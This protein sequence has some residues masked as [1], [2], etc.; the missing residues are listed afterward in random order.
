MYQLLKGKKI[1]FS[2]KLLNHNHFYTGIQ[3]P[4]GNYPCLTVWNFF[5]LICKF[6]PWICLLIKSLV[7]LNFL[8]FS[9]D[10]IDQISLP[11]H[12]V[13]IRKNVNLYVQ[14]FR[15]LVISHYPWGI[16]SR[17]YHGNQNLTVLKFYSWPSIS[18]VP[19]L[20]IEPTTNRVVLYIFVE[21][22][23]HKSRP[24]QFKPMLFKGQLDINSDELTM[25]IF[26]VSF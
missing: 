11:P 14:Q 8:N 18:I 4:W 1:T 15:T 16:G 9:Y 21:K 13:E 23:P 17:T 5:F 2:Q 3:N 22:N 6:I 26:S 19:H 25:A 10:V 20:W 24:T 12:N 7:N